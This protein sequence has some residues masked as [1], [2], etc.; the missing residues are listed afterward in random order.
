MKMK[1]AG[2]SKS[3]MTSQVILSMF[4]I[5]I[6]STCNDNNLT[7]KSSA[8][9][10]LAFTL[11][12]QTGEAVIDHAAR[13][14]TILVGSDTDLTTLTPGITVSPKATYTPSGAQNFTNPVV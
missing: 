12:Q 5:L 1:T 4:S 13:T 14:V 10:I 3:P 2:F 8:K 11:L 7:L 9:D 6:F